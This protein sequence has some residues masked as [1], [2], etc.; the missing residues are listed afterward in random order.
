MNGRMW[1]LPEQPEPASTDCCGDPS[2]CNRECEHKDRLR[3]YPARKWEG[4][5][6]EDR[7]FLRTLRIGAE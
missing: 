3:Q 2:D 5:T 6:A 4:L 1:G 7:R